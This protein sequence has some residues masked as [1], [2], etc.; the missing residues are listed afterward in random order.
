MIENPG[1][2]DRREAEDYIIEEPFSLGEM[3]RAINTSKPTS[4]GEDQVC[5]VLCIGLS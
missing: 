3:V 5:Y 4:P 1:E 2:I